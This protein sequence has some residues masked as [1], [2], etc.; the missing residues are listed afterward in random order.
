MSYQIEPF[1]P[2]DSRRT[3]FSARAINEIVDGINSL[4][5]LRVGEGLEFDATKHN[6]VLSLTPALLQKIEE[7]GGGTGSI[8]FKGKWEDTGVSYEVG[9]IVIVFDLAEAGVSS[10][11]I[12]MKVG[13]YICREDHVS[14]T[15]KAPPSGSTYENTEWRT[16]AR[17]HFEHFWSH[18]DDK[19]GTTH[20]QGGNLTINFGPRT[21]TLL[22]NPARLILD[23]TVFGDGTVETPCPETLKGKTFQPILVDICDDG[24]AKKMWVIGTAPF[25]P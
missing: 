19:R 22:G 17:G 5:N 23:D 1:S 6:A 8:S 18:Y 14:S 4:L 24:V 10:A 21:N 25:T 16:L 9:D 3:A 11:D 15:A 7:G 2:G 20:V 13:T 12:A